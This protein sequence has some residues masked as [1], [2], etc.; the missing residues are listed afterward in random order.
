MTEP[1]NRRKRINW[2]QAAG[3]AVLLLAGV[4]LALAA[5]A[6]WE[7]QVEKRTV[8]EHVDNLL[9][10][11]RENRG[12]LEFVISRHKGQVDNCARLIE[13]LAAP[14]SSAE[15]V[16]EI[17]GLLAK[18]LF[19][20]DF[21]PATSALQNLVGAGDVGMLGDTGLQLAISR[22]GRALDAHMTL[23]QELAALF[24]NRFSDVVGDYLPLVAAGYIS[25]EVDLQP[26]DSAFELDVSRLRGQMTFENMLARRISAEQ[27]AR[28][29]AE[30]L[31][32]RAD[33]LIAALEALE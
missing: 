5:Q 10:E 29:F 26:D 6:W 19:F 16:E 30:R 20:D 18:I 33:E 1:Q 25:R 2:R 14:D 11:L 31:V 27:D 13:L 3:E 32:A 7:H 22:Y 8:R 9:V 24:L 15:Q 23:Q 28:Q 21:P 17:E 12:G 4:L